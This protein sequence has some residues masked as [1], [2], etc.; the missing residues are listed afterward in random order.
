MKLMVLL[1][2]KEWLGDVNS[3]NTQSNYS[4]KQLREAVEAI[5]NSRNGIR[6]KLIMIKQLLQ[7]LKVIQ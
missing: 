3:M 7:S 4:D 1:I 5:L 6:R 2:N